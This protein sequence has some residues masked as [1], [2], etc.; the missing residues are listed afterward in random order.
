MYCFA[1]ISRKPAQIVFAVQVS[2]P[3]GDAA[4]AVSAAAELCRARRA[5]A[6]VDASPWQVDR[7]EMVACR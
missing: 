5:G 6:S 1:L 2:Y 3:F 7:S 4:T